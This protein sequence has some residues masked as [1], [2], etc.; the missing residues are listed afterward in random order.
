MDLLSVDTVTNDLTVT[1]RDAATK[2]SDK[3]NL[4]KSQNN[5]SQ[6]SA[7]NCI[8]GNVLNTSRT[9]P[10]TMTTGNYY[11]TD[12]TMDDNNKRNLILDTT[13]GDINIAVNKPAGDIIWKKANISVTGTHNVKIWLNGG[14]DAGSGSDNVHIN[15]YG[16]TNDTSSRFQVV[17]SSYRDIKFQRGGT[18]F[19]GFVYAPRAKLYVQQGAK[20]F[21]ALVGYQFSV[22]NSQQIYFDEALQNLNTDLGEGII[23]M[24]LHITQNDIGVSIN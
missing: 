24:Y 16:N 18:E 6:P 14:I 8:N 22:D 1:V 7:G 5:N 19:C 15:R 12:F 20:I 10:C 3:I 9:D 2:V 23:I 11:L 21:G 17:S 13:V 4:Y